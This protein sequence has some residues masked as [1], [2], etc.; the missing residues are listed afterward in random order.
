MNLPLHARS[1]QGWFGGW[2]EE[3]QERLESSTG[4]HLL[5]A[6]QVYELP[7]VKLATDP[8]VKANITIGEMGRHALACRRKV[9]CKL[10][11]A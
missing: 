7:K 2:D 5:L 11:H 9:L 1:P 10:P 6:P 8:S 4:R 3:H